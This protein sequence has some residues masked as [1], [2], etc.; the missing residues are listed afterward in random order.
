MM[1]NEYFMI[2]TYTVYMYIA[3]IILVIS[4]NFF[5]SISRFQGNQSINQWSDFKM[6]AIQ[7]NAI[8]TPAS[9]CIL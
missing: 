9:F 8:T 3:V 5:L 1:G 4:F 7:W 2:T 6:K